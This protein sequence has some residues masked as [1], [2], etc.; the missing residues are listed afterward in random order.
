MPTPRSGVGANV[1]HGKIYVTG[2]YV[3][4]SS[5]LTGSSFVSLNE[6]YNP[7][8]DSWT[9]KAEVPTAVVSSRSAVVDSKIYIIQNDLTQIYDAVTDTWSFG[10][11]RPLISISDFRTVAT[12]GVNAL[13]QVYGFGGGLTQVYDPE[14]DSWMFGADMLT[15]R[16]GF[17]VA[18]VN[19][20]LY[21]I[22]GF[23]ETFDMFW[24]SDVTLYAAN[25]Q[26]TPFGYGTP[27]PSFDGVAPEISVVSPENKTYFTEDVGLNFRADEP[28]F[29]VHYALDGGVPVEISGN[30]TLS[31]LAVGA[32][33][34]SVFGFDASGNMGTSETVCFAVAELEPFP[35]VLVAAAFAASVAVA[36]AGLLFYLRRRNHG[37]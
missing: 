3:P 13:K 15:K 25:E 14:S 30:M 1:V 20:L 35:V 23:T 10:T 33:N 6:V 31:G 26:Y 32:H 4:N 21:V 36:V 16:V 19:D 7:E 2:G 22:G 12:S 27:D 17:G 11:S 8:T 5:S 24:N 9:T 18:V 37:A 29:S 28:V 34:V